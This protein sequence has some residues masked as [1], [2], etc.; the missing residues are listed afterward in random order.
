[1]LI[2]AS[3]REFIFFVCAPYVPHGE[4]VAFLG[5]RSPHSLVR[6]TP[7]SGRCSGATADTKLSQAIIESPPLASL[8]LCTYLHIHF[9]LY[10]TVLLPYIFRQ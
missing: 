4:H 5:L 9:P 6:Q 3:S 1:M 8:S 7:L 10:I 2:L